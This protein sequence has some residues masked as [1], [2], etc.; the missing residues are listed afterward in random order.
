MRGLIA[1]GGMIT[2]LCGAPLG[3]QA[4]QSCGRLPCPDITGPYDETEWG[5]AIVDKCHQG[6]ILK[7]GAGFSS[8]VALWYSHNPDN[9]P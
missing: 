8:G 6:K 4:H 1:F 7:G 9:P 3:E 5:L 2:I